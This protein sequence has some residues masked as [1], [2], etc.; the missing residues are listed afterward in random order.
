MTTA[1]LVGLRVIVGHDDEK[2]RRRLMFNF[3]RTCKTV[4]DMNSMRKSDRTPL[5]VRR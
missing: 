1:A 4:K 5:N 2:A 3:E